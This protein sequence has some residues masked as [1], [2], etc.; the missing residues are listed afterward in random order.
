MEIL[1]VAIS[2]FNCRHVHLFIRK[3]NKFQSGLQKVGT[4]GTSG[5][6]REAKRFEWKK[7]LFS[8]YSYTFLREN[9]L[10]I[11][12]VRGKITSTFDVRDFSFLKGISGLGVQDF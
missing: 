12:V 10:F 11:L 5:R 7:C 4:A 6:Y 2:Y 8:T 9:L 1:S 3:F